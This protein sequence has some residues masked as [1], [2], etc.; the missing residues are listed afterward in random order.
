MY[1]TQAETSP[2]TFVFFVNDP[3]LLHFSYRRFLE[4]RIRAA[5]GFEGTSIRMV[6]RRR[7]EDRHE[8]PA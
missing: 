4:N 8:V 1:V 6:F 3:Q 7:S 2:P 5:F